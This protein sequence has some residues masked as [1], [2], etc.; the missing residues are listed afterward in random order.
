MVDGPRHQFL[1][2]SGFAGYQDRLA[3]PGDPRKRFKH[4]QHARRRADHSARASLGLELEPQQQVL[5]PHGANFR[6]A[7]ERGLELIGHEGF[8]E[9]VVCTQADGLDGG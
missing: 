5:S 2:R 1:A 9:I 7:L 3:L 6:Q 8:H 4:G